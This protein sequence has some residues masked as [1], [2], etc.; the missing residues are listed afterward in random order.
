MK[1]RLLSNSKVRT[2]LRIAAAGSIALG[3]LA[4]HPALPVAAA[5]DMSVVPIAW[6]TI[7]LDSNDVAAG[8]NHFPVGATVC[9]LYCV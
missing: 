2:A 4:A 9:N 5:A 1:S 7:G 6:N 8:P 3:W